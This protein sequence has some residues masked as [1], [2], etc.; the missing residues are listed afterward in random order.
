MNTR[1]TTAACWIPTHTQELRWNRIQWDNHHGRRWC[2]IHT[3]GPESR[4]LGGATVATPDPN[5]RAY[6]CQDVPDSTRS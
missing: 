5:Q 2:H 6:R 1:P 4:L 3:E